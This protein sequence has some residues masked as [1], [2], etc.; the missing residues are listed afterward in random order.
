MNN[1]IGGVRRMG[2]LKDKVKIV[3]TLLPIVVAIGITGVKLS[4][5]YDY[6]D[7]YELGEKVVIEITE[8][9][10]SDYTALEDET[11]AVIGEEKLELLRNYMQDNDLKLKCGGYELNEVYTYDEIL[12][13]LEFVE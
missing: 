12:D 10:S 7:N 9:E 1:F 13:V 5:L 8:E 3:A 6:V 11:F 4:E 2:N